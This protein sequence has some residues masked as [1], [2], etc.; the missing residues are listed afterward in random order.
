LPGILF[1][2]LVILQLKIGEVVGRCPMKEFYCDESGQ[3]MAEYG[4]LVTLV[5]VAVIGSIILFRNQLITYW[6]TFTGKLQ[7]AS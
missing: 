4:L 3:G 1:G 6:Q 5:A 2:F 7:S